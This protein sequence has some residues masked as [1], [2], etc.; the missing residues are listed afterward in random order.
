MR[1]KLPVFDLLDVVLRGPDAVTSSP[2][3]AA[4][5]SGKSDPH[6]RSGSEKACDQHCQRG[7]RQPEDDQGAVADVRALQVSGVLDGE[8]DPVMEDP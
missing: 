1:D 2:V 3:R 6:D 4:P 7:D 5:T 8:T